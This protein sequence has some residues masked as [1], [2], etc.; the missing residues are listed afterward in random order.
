MLSLLLKHPKRDIL[1][2][3]FPSLI[4]GNRLKFAIHLFLVRAMEK[5]GSCLPIPG[6]F[7]K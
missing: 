1:V 7:K 5:I 2:Q 4:S 3:G 6:L